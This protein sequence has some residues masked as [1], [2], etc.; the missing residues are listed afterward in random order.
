MS[1]APPSLLVMASD[2]WLVALPQFLSLLVESS[3]DLVP[4]ELIHHS[5]VNYLFPYIVSS[6][7]EAPILLD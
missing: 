1:H 4:K 2:P 5:F 7:S 6:P 3:F